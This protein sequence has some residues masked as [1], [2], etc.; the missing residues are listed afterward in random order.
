MCSWEVSFGCASGEDSEKEPRWT[1][2]RGFGSHLDP[3][4]SCMEGL[5]QVLKSARPSFLTHK[6]GMMMVIISN[7]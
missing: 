1:S 7:L 5:E 4:T 2:Q 3:A 6:M